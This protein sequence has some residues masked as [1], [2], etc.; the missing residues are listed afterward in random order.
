MAM[1]DFTII[2]RSMRVRLFSTCVTMATVALSVGLM[3]LLLSMRDSGQRAF[4]RGSGNMHLLISRDSSALTSIL[5]GIFYA[6]PPQRPIE[7]AK[8]VSIRDSYPWEFAIPTQLGDSY[9]GQYPV[10]ATTSDFF[11]RFRPDPDLEW[12]LTDGRFL[13]SDFEIVLGAEVARGTGL[14]VGDELFVTHGSR[15]SREADVEDGAPEGDSHEDHAASPGDHDDGHVHGDDGGHV[16]REFTYRVV[17][18]LARTGAAHDRA[19]FTSLESA[20][21]THAHERRER[22]A[23]GHVETTTAADLNDADRLITGIYARVITRPG[24]DVSAAMQQIFDQ[25]RRDTS[26]TV[27]APGA[28]IPRLFRLVT[29]VNYI[30]L[31]MA[32]AVMV[33]SGVG[34]M[35]ALYNSMDQRRRQMAILRVLGCSRSRV[36]G[37]VLTESA[38][39]G[40]AGA[41]LGFLVCVLG[42]LATR[43][44]LKSVLG[45]VI[46]PSFEAKWVIAVSL[47]AVAL[48]CFAGLIPALAA[49]RT[50]VV[51]NLRPEP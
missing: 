51:R 28:E 29:N 48:A 33:V 13:E 20:W 12:E 50:P 34:I 30:L 35:L 41:V 4:E 5:N 22:E 42:T 11:T 1:T 24:A 43:A 14:R 25:L 45:L 7:W 10:V 49:Y 39:I 26:I 44:A 15:G 17:G 18:T 21:I 46:E 31:A 40:I 23:G 32:G 27:A 3:L 37:L 36:F 19:L 38:L 47:G 16:H 6:S 2:C 8:Y 9:A